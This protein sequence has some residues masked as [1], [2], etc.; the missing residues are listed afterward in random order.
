MSYLAARLGAIKPS[1]TLSLNKKAAEL[2]AE[3]RDV[4]ALSAGEP[5]FHTPSWICDAAKKAIDDGKTLYTDVVGTPALRKAVTQKFIKENNLEYDPSEA[6]VSTGGKQVLFN[7]FLSTLN[8]GDE[9]IIPAPY[10]VSYPDMVLLAGGT[11]VFVPCPEDD[12]FKLTPEG[13]RKAIAPRT[14]WLV[15]NSPSNPTGAVYTKEELKALAD[16]L[17]QHP[18]VLALCDDIY[19]HILY[20]GL[21]FTTLA[22]VEPRLK[23]RVLTLN[24]VSKAYAMTGWRIGFAVGPKAL[25]T[26]MGTLQSQSTSNP[27]SIAQEAALAAL[28]GP[29]KF[30]KDFKESFQSRRD[31][32]VTLINAIDGLS[33]RAPDG[34]FYLYVCCDGLLGRTTPEGLHLETDSDVCAYFLEKADV[35]VVPGIAFGLSPYFRISYATSQEVLDTACARLA[36]AVARLS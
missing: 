18:H 16:V 29:K 32:T 9:V 15:L 8:P 36:Q 31:R 6:I 4:I 13:L 22:Q 20:T 34:A 24:G 19:E 14:K 7:A 25:I 12:G 2:R 17:M 35:A 23:D 1:P 30:L 21:P 3:G 26:A 27:C 10:W 33:C 28:E 5:D 11:P